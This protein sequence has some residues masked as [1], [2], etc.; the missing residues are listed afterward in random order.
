MGGWQNFMLGMNVRERFIALKSHLL[1]TTLVANVS[2]H[3]LFL[4]SCSQMC[5]PRDSLLGIQ[6]HSRIK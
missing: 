3:L 5:F 6:L 2:E 1:L 4:E